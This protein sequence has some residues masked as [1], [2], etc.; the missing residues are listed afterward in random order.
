M[1]KYIKFTLA[2]GL[3][4]HVHHN[5]LFEYCYDYDERVDVIKIIKPENEQE[6]RLRLFKM[7][8]SEAMKALPKKLIKANAEC[9]KANAECDKAHADRDK[10]NAD[11]DKARAEWYKARADRD[12]AI[13]EWD[14]AYAEWDKA[15]A[16]W[17]GKEEWHKKY[18]G[19]KEWDG[20]KINF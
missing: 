14:K 17:F 18:C 13:A 9:D 7:L 12:K 1:K 16:E 4:F 5:I 11:R 6:I 15:R 10:A 3:A 8:S 19:C 2:K 20:K